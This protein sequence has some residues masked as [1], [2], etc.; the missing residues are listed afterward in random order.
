MDF[1]GVVVALAIVIAVILVFRFLVL[2]YWRVNEA[3]EL[4][5][6]INLKLGRILEKMPEEAVVVK[7]SS[8]VS[9]D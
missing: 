1:I 7:Q 4:L 8:L 5:M 3:V 6:N 9:R 2:W